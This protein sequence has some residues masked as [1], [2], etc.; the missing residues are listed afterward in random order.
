MKSNIFG[1]QQSS[2]SFFLFFVEYFAADPSNAFGII[3]RVF[4]LIKQIDINLLRSFV[5]S[6]ISLYMKVSLDLIEFKLN[7]GLF[8]LYC[9]SIIDVYLGKLFITNIITG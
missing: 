4:L 1:Q 5:K 9:V 6:L 8:S 3:A 7:S 2:I